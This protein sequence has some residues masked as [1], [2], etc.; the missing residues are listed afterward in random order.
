MPRR[1]VT[2]HRWQIVGAFVAVTA[3][4]VIGAVIFAGW[5]N[6]RIADIQQSRI[7]SCRQTYEGVRQV[8]RP[9]LRPPAKR[10]AKERRDVRKFNATVNELKRR[11]DVQIKRTPKGA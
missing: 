9:F 6:D 11:C 2:L 8:F 10:S 7:A 5:N 3:G 4:F 1:V